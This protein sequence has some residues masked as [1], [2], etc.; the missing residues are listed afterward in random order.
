V[1][2][3]VACALLPLGAVA[4]LAYG[5]VGRQLMRD[6]EVRAERGAKL[7]GQAV[8]E[9]LRRIE[10]ALGAAGEALADGRVAVEIPGTQ[11]LLWDRA[12]GA[13][14]PVRGRSFVP[15][16]LTSAMRA[17]LAAGGSVLRLGHDDAEYPVAL[18]ARAVA[19]G[20]SEGTLWAILDSDALAEGLPFAPA[21]ATVCLFSDGRA[22]ACA[23]PG[24]APLGSRLAG[25]F[26]GRTGFADAPP[27]VAHW[28]DPA[29]GRPYVVGYWEIFLRPAFLADAWTIA[30][31]EPRAD[32]LQPLASFNRT[33]PFVLLLA[34]L[35]VVL[36]SSVQIR[37][38]LEPL[39]RLAAGTRRLARRDFS[40]PV[41]VGSGDEFQELAD[42]FNDM[43]LQ[44]DRQFR[45][46]ETRSGIDRAVLA[47][48]D[49]GRIVDI[50]LGELA[51]LV[52]TDAV[53]LA[54]A[55]PEDE[56]AWQVAARVGGARYV[57]QVLPGAHEVADLARGPEPR[58][59]P[60]DALPVYVIAPLDDGT[61][62]LVVLPL[63]LNRSAVGALVL[64]YAGNRVGAD[65]IESARRVADQL[66]VALA[67]ARLL[68][69]LH[70]MN[71][72][73][74]ASLARAIDAKS[75][76][77]AGHS[78]RVTDLALALGRRLGLSP[79]ELDD[80]HRGGLLHDV[81][82]IGVPGAVLDKADRLTADEM[83]AM[84]RHVQVGASIIAPIP[85][86]AGALPVV[87]YHHERW[88]GSGYPDGRRGDAIPWLARVLAV[89][90]VY[91]ALTSERPYRRGLPPERAIAHIRDQAAVQFD[92]A[93]VDVLLAEMA[94]RGLCPDSTVDGRVE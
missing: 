86:H 19:G 34:F 88:D 7:S 82:K 83:E 70:H 12:N 28:E 60:P 43:A 4:A 68:D 64:G 9:R 2:L 13:M 38:S 62:R 33:F 59:L 76:W 58:W 42:S 61:R 39:G 80:L 63:I 71:W 84:R 48:L 73:M 18:M 65:M 52:G 5:Y 51:P 46:I 93:V 37:R 22:L 78:D 20:V 47:A 87:L 77:T 67:N 44:L 36:F 79:E 45:A 91:D 11:G 94:A 31:A 16:S 90:D 29:D 75:P 24:A 27:R 40:E 49:T 15:G 32:V 6:A 55:P 3:F 23:L 35:A 14:R 74:V 57:R 85:G 53:A 41:R 66:T 1:L 17:H 92:P 56:A 21:G 8:I 50:V 26:A 69:R 89:A 30:V 10:T 72:G 54:L 81:G 25:A